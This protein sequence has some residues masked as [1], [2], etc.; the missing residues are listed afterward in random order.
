MKNG[1]LIRTDP[2]TKKEYGASCPKLKSSRRHGTCGVSRD[3]A[4][5]DGRAS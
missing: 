2:K 4:G 3:T 1:N 5:R